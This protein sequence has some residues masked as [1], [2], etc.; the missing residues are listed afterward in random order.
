M[1]CSS[2]LYARG[3]PPLARRLRRSGRRRLGCRPGLLLDDPQERVDDLGIELAA[4]LSIDLGNRF[5]DGPRR[6]VGTLLR[7][8]SKTSATVTM[9]PTS[10]IS[11]PAN[12]A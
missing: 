1:F 9:R 5:F 6:L 8:A 4:A 7:Q 3:A 12:P 2:F 10:G 11:S